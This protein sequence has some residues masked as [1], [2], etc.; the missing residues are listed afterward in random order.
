MKAIIRIRGQVSGNSKLLAAITTIDSKS[1]SS[2]FNG[3]NVEFP[4]RKA[5]YLALWHG[6]LSLRLEPGFKHGVSYS[7]G[8]LYYD[9]SSAILER[10]NK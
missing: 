6:Y 1:G 7:R 10:D 9:A 3:Y 2:S 8:Y 5:A 4:S